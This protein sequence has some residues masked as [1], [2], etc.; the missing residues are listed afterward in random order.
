MPRRI[1]LL[2]NLKVLFFISGFALSSGPLYLALIFNS[3]FL[4]SKE[5]TGALMS[6]IPAINFFATP[7][8][9]W[10]GE[11]KIGMKL[12]YVL[13]TIIGGL[14]FALISLVPNGNS[15][16][17]YYLG[18][19]CAIYALT[20]SSTTTILDGITVMLLK[21]NSAGYG[22]IRIWLSL[23]W[24]IG[25]IC[26]GTIQEK[27]GNFLVPFYVFSSALL[28]QIM[29]QLPLPSMKMIN[30]QP[31][32]SNP[33]LSLD[34]N[35]EP[36]TKVPI[37]TDILRSSQDMVEL[38]ANE[39]GEILPSLSSNDNVP[40][41]ANLA[42]YRILLQP[43]TIFYL[44]MVTIMGTVF[45]TIGT[46]LFIFITVELGG[47]PLLIGLT[48][49]IAI[50]LEL[51]TFYFAKS[52][53]AKLGVTKMLIMAHLFLA[54]RL[55][56]YLLITKESAYSILALEVLHGVAFG[57]TWTSCI[58][59]GNI[60]APSSSKSTFIAIYSSLWKNIGGLCGTI[61]GGVIYQRLGYKLLWAWCLMLLCV[62]FVMFGMNRFFESR[63]RKDP[64]RE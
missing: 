36:S 52:I 43:R 51:P 20:F 15:A 33:D 26:T 16:T 47:S 55:G 22:K 13:C 19:L 46:F 48:T 62:S 37:T 29:F 24:G 4:L 57:L 60:I 64:A 49:P 45:S 56:G 31:I 2:L 54:L 39:N 9:T 11:H 6:I 1:P 61:I 8:V 14:A 40:E 63:I 3:V 59:Y 53:L 18:A 25:S 27:T 32:S 17:I 21:N 10:I 23:A 50:L 7:V 42:L 35:D 30:G 5:Q 12:I 41:S 28:V 34:L 58:E 44:C 38:S